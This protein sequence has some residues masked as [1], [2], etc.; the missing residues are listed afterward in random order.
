MTSASPSSLTVKVPARAGTG[1]V[2]VN[3]VAAPIKFTYVPE[4]FITGYISDAAGL[5]RAMYWKNGV[6]TILAGTGLSTYANEIAVVNNDIYVVGSRQ[7]P[8]YG[9][10]RWW[11][12]GQEMPITNDAYYSSAEGIVVS[13]TDV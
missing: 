5:S 3:G 11:K 8:L 4:V 1:A 12:N 2:V 13:G 10:A 9:V 7:L 6:P